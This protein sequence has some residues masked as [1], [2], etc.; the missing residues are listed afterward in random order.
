MRLKVFVEKHRK[1]EY[2]KIFMLIHLTMTMKKN[3]ILVRKQPWK[4]L[5]N[6]YQRHIFPQ[7]LKKL[8]KINNE[9]KRTALKRLAK[10]QLKVEHLRIGV[11]LGNQNSQYDASDLL[12]P[13]TKTIKDTIEKFF[14]RIRLYWKQL[15]MSIKKFLWLHTLVHKKHLKLNLILIQTY[16]SQLQ[17]VTKL[18]IKL[19]KRKKRNPDAIDTLKFSLGYNL[20]KNNNWW[21]R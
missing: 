7:K 19:T 9:E 21:S 2:I 17:E 14:E 5:R 12:A 1:M 16:L 15:T 3:I 13:I 8:D 11:K 10:S 18:M 4:N 20:D 6:V